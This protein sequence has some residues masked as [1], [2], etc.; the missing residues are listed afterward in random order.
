MTNP[1]EQ[2]QLL[3]RRMQAIGDELG[4]E[5]KGFMV[6]PAEDEDAA[7]LAQVMFVVRSE[8][9]SGGE[10]TDD[11][12]MREQFD[13][14]TAGFDPTGEEDLDAIRKDVGDWLQ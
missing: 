8:A 13:A 11:A 1:M 5:L 2:L 9:F 14:I 4:L 7:N 12:L 10:D 6:L 3:R